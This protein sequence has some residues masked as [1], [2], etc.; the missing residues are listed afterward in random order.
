MKQKKKTIR[1]LFPELPTEGSFVEEPELFSFKIPPDPPPFF[2]S[3]T[4]LLS[5]FLL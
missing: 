3:S 4:E 1:R 2:P 5:Q